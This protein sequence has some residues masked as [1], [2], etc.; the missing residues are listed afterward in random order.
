[1]RALL[2]YPLQKYINPAATE[3]QILR[4]SHGS[5]MQ[6][7]CCF[8]A[9]TLLTARRQVAFFALAMGLLGLIFFYIGISMGWL[10][11]SIFRSPLRS[12]V[13]FHP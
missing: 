3:S 1:M 10:Y 5:V 8:W 12:L 9:T 11:V 13:H 7:I 6:I 2:T 4:V